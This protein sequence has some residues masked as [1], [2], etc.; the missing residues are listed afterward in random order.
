MLSLTLFQNTTLQTV[1]KALL[2]LVYGLAAVS[3]LGVLPA[4]LAQLLQ[5]VSLILLAIH[6][7]EVLL[8]FKW[9]RLYRGSLAVSILLTLLFGLL[10]WKPIADAHRPTAKD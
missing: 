8:M 6:V 1:L 2:V 10:H 3:L 5:R 9:V 7:V 4:D